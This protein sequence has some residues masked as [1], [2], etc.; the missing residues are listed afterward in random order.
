MSY[1]IACEVFRPE[2]E[3]LMRGMA[4]APEVTWL[5]QGLHETP[6]DLRAKVQEAVDAL[7]EKGA[8]TILLAYGLCGRGLA[9][10][11]G[12]AATLVLPRAHDCIPVLIGA[13][14]EHANEC[15]LGGSTYWLSPGWLAYPQTF[16]FRDRAQRYR[17]YEEKYG[18]DAA[19]YLVEVE[20]SW[21]KNYTNACLILWDGWEDGEK[22]R[23]DAR[24]VAEDAGLG[25]RECPGG[26]DFLAALLAGGR[27]GRFLRLPPGFTPDLDGDGNIVPRPADPV[28]NPASVSPAAGATAEGR[29]D[30]ASS[31]ALP[32]AAASRLSPPSPADP[33][34][35]K[36][37]SCA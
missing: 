34:G 1:L 16:F 35:E 24:A 28:T 4:D 27:D 30:K 33:A 19:A 9:G 31:A 17:D 3:R 22:L 8:A 23:A 6:D 7:E 2:L 11:T 21:L 14:Q 12:R 10:V 36:E 37:A 13:T 25:Y 26:P 20:A 32:G 18:P 15:A 5:E 29:H